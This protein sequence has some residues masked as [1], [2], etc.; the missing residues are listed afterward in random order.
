MLNPSSARRRATLASV[1]VLAGAAMLA[2]GLNSSATPSRGA[3]LAKEGSA[4]KT[5]WARYGG[6][7]SADYTAYN[8]LA[9]LASPPAPAVGAVQKLDGPIAGDPANGAKL[10][11]DRAR[12]GSCVA[13]HVMGPTTPDL[14]GN[15]G[16]DLSTIGSW[17]RSDEILYNYIYDPRV[18]NPAT[19]M[20][21]WGAHGVFT[22]EEIR[23]IVAFLKTLTQPTSFR[24]ELD[25]PAK[26]PPPVE[27]RDNLDPTENPAVWA[28]DQAAVVFNRSGP[29]GQSCASCHA[30][31]E[32]AFSAWA[33]GMPRFEPGLDKVLGVEEFITRHARATT[34][35]ELLMQSEDNTALA[36]YLRYLA[37]G[38]PIAVD[39]QSPG[40][41]AAMERGQALMARKIG[42]LNF[43]CVDCHSIGANRWI[44]GQWLGE[45][46]G[47]LAHF[48][49]WRTS[50]SETWDIRKRF[51]WCNV[52]IRANELPPDAREYA[53]LELVLASFNQGLPLS[54]PGIRH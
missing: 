24:S 25:D 12:G 10:A 5:P 17:G 47:Q 1:A 42:Q 18:Y 23:D 8:T 3:P 44:R 6:W 34:G 21:P 7:P 45:S 48:P 28:L 35:E 14:P 15:V 29:T 37:N 31:P 52:A 51:Q 38:A 2:V 46:R 32:Q 43:A 49:T 13:C 53:D 40:A 16:P 39:T 54:V 41:K 19:V 27:T 9:H 30:E 4:A 22:P 50:R 33:A 11:Y 26:R 36:I 20:P